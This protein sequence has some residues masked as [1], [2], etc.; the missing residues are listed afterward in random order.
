MID[1]LDGNKYWVAPNQPPKLVEGIGEPPELDLDTNQRFQ[2]S[3]SAAGQWR[4]SAATVF[5]EPLRRFNDIADKDPTKL[6]GADQRTIVVNYAKMLDPTSAVMENEADAVRKAGEK[7]PMF[8]DWWR[9]IIDG[10]M[11]AETMANIMLEAEQL[12][13]KRYAELASTY[14]SYQQRLKLYGQEDP[15]PWIGEMPQ[16]PKPVQ[17]MVDKYGNVKRRG[18]SEEDKDP[19]NGKDPKELK[20]E[21]D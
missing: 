1:G 3:Q 14:G 21:Y 7:M 20:I 11:P 2:L 19:F 8:N 10:S 13:V 4:Q 16:A 18:E 12:A 17:Y 9:Q 6:T 5:K 15:I